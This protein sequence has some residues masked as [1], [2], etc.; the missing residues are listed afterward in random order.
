MGVYVGI[1]LLRGLLT[2]SLISP[3]V[4]AYRTPTDYVRAKYGM[5]RQV[6]YRPS[7]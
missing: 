6:T 5:Y 7:G 4:T 3:M 2:H 1:P